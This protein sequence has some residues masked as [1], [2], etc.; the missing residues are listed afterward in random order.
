MLFSH[1]K[2]PNT[3]FYG[4][5][6]DKNDWPKVEG[7]GPDHDFRHDLHVMH[8]AITKLGLWKEFAKDPGEHGFMF[9]TDKHVMT[10]MKDPEVVNCGHSG[11][12]AGYAM[13]IMQYI[14]I[15][16]WDKFL[17][18]NDKTNSNT[19]SALKPK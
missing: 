8:T 13:R 12:T 16:G 6:Q 10:L 11:V 19:K 1:N 4:S 3:K 5:P 17:K 9:S 18:T 2:K 7:Y 15:Y 14:A